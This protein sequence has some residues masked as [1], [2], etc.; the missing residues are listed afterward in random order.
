MRVRDGAC[1]SLLWLTSA[2]VAGC[3]SSSGDGADAGEVDAGVTV[4]PVELCT[5]V[6]AAHCEL[7]DRCYPAF[8]RDIPSNCRALE[9]NR[10]LQT[11]TALKPSFEARKVEI[12]VQQV[13]ACEQRMRTS[14]CTP[15]FPPGYP[16]VATSPFEDCQLGTGLLRGKVPSGETC[17]NAVECAS[18]SICIK[19]GGVCTGTCSSLPREGEPCAFGCGPGLYC[20]SR[21]TPES[22]DDR[23]APLK[24]ANETCKTSRECHDDLWCD[25]VCKQRGSVGDACAFDAHRLSTCAPGLA[26]DV[27]P[28][29]NQPGVCVAPLPQ[30]APCRYH[31]S[32]GPGLLCWD[33]DFSD[34]P[35]APPPQA[36]TCAPPAPAGLGCAFSPYAVFLG[37]PCEAGTACQ[38]NN[39]CG[40]RPVLGE[41]C[42]PLAQT[43]A[44]QEVYCKPS[45]TTEDQGTCTGPAPLNQRCASRLDGDRTIQ[46]PCETG[47]CDTET[48]LKCLPP[49]KAVGQDCAS[50]GECLSGRCAVQEDRTLRCAA[51]CL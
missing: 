47:W 19:P 24:G 21:Q 36:G 4:S 23:C 48:T 11:Y 2:A 42:H 5:R 14:S 45:E 16:D 39:L 10:C 15:S 46:I 29:L 51:A 40:T 35:N 7:L 50:N 26:C 9:Q 20:D 27:P 1:L 49:D 44:G 12:D 32:C 6:A 37:D 13:E 38:Q 17:V 31:W 41:L 43:C 28:F 25:Q 18:G 33:L 3:S 34:F 8:R 30:G 22:F